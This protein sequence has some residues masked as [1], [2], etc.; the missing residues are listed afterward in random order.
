M[1]LIQPAPSSWR[2]RMLSIFRVVAAAMFVTFG[3]MKLFNYPASP[4]PGFPVNVWSEIGVAGVLETFG[5]LAILLGLFTRPVSFLLAG[6]MA[7]A[8]FKAH[9]P[10]GFF[11]SSNG[12]VPA[13][14]YCFF[15]LYLMFAGGGEWSVDALLARSR[16]SL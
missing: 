11:P 12:G 6:L 2:E 7:V 16:R 3:T 8:Y 15:F 1:S 9:A 13:V 10:Q 5:G 14:L 4:F